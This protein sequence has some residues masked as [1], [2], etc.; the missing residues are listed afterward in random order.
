LNVGANTI[1]SPVE[2]D[3]SGSRIECRF[4]LIPLRVS[5]DVERADQ[6]LVVE[7]HF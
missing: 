4:F 6:W 3:S 2:S 7:F 1:L 5:Q